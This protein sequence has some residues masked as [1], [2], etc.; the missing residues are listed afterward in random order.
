MELP[1]Q[2]KKFDYIITAIR[3]FI[4]SD[5]L[6][7]KSEKLRWFCQNVITYSPF[8]CVYGLGENFT[9][10]LGYNYDNYQYLH[11]SYNAKNCT[12]REN[13]ITTKLTD[14]DIFNLLNKAKIE[15]I[16][17]ILE[18]T[19]NPPHEDIKILIEKQYNK[20]V[21]PIDKSNLFEVASVKFI[22][23]FNC[24]FTN[25]DFIRHT[26]TLEVSDKIITITNQFNDYKFNISKDIFT[27]YCGFNSLIKNCDDDEV[28][29]T[30]TTPFPFNEKA[31]QFLSKCLINTGINNLNGLKENDIME[32]KQLISF[33]QITLSNK[34]SPVIKKIICPY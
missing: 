15:D 32:I 10:Y 14:Q 2:F 5:Y 8:K 6:L 18:N 28:I 19:I 12:K 29:D 1:D 16:K 31:G 23:H 25:I 17:D 7:T 30:I 13:G 20:K 34:S 24:L 3:H 26:T 4:F 22:I 21:F 27:V 33:L 9:P 11:V